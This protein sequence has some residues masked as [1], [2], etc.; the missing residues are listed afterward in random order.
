MWL[1]EPHLFLA[2]CAFFF[3]LFLFLGVFSCLWNLR[4]WRKARSR[5]RASMCERL[6]GFRSLALLALQVCTYLFMQLII[7][8][9]WARALQNQTRR[10]YR[11]APPRLQLPTIWSTCAGS[12]RC[13]RVIDNL[14]RSGLTFPSVLPQQ[15]SGSD[16]FD[17]AL[18]SSNRQSS[19]PSSSSSSSQSEQLWCERALPS[20]DHRKHWP[21]SSAVAPGRPRIR[22]VRNF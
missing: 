2:S 3:L 7:S 22:K 13:D 4:F 16:S 17:E 11:I 9:A 6:D 12:V 15:R 18:I 14:P 10:L 5:K 21:L 19:R 20:A 8:G 1:P